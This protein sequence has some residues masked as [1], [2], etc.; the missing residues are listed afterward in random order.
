MPQT[1][2][3]ANRF[4]YSCTLYGCTFEFTC[5]SVYSRAGNSS[6]GGSVVTCGAD[7]RWDF[8]NLHCTGMCFRLGSVCKIYISCKIWV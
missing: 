5:R 2:K 6:L 1:V 4:M 3:G 8:G 7:G